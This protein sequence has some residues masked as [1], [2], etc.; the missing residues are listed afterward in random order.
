LIT[1]GERGA[2]DMLDIPW[3]EALHHPL[4]GIIMGRLI[5]LAG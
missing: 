2:T 4:T 3:A 5:A 1:P